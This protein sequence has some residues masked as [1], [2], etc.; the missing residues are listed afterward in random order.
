MVR[1]EC[2]QSRNKR[3]RQYSR[4]R[5]TVRTGKNISELVNIRTGGLIAAHQCKMV[6]TDAADCTLAAEGTGEAP[7]RKVQFVTS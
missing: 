1:Q 7:H 2:V 6:P 3:V 5:L 4:V